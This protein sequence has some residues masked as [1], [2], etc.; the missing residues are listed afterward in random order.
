MKTL[1]DTYLEEDA[2]ANSL[3]AGKNSPTPA[4]S[5]LLGW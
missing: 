5:L 3:G 2:P 4:V 1:L